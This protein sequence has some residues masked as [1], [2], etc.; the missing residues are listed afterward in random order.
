MIEEEDIYDGFDAYKLYLAVKSH[1]SS[2]YDFFKY[3][4]RI[5]AYKESY[6]KRNDRFLFKR[7]EKQFSRKEIV[8][9]FVSNFV[10]DKDAW[11]GVHSLDNYYEWKKV[12]ESLGYVFEEDMRK[13]DD[14]LADNKHNFDFMF[15]PV[16][17]FPPLF[18]MMVRE[19]IRIESLIIMDEVL[20]FMKRWDVAMKDDLLW[21]KYYTNIRNF[22][23][24]L[25]FDAPKYKTIMQ[26]IFT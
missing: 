11:I 12:Q 19:D 2:K 21:Q 22:R 10:K 8:E 18:E 13:I 7:I 4:G 25:K 16:D 6:L 20:D 15:V 3:D 9:I 17:G 23:P 14:W 26:K 24:F 5:K 1:F